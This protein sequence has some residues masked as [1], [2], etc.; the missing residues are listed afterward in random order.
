MY[1]FSFLTMLFGSLFLAV[2]DKFEEAR[3]RW[4]LSTV[5]TLLVVAVLVIIGAA[6]VYV[7]VVVPT[8]TTT[9]TYP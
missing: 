8:I 5:V 3:G 6:C 9:S 4:A 1:A 2:D 7:L